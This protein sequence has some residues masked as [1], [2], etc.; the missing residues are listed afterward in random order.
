MK[1][2]TLKEVVEFYFD[3]HIALPCIYYN[4]GTKN[5]WNRTIES[6]NPTT[7]D[8]RLSRCKDTF[9]IYTSWITIKIESRDAGWDDLVCRHFW[10]KTF[11]DIQ[12]LIERNICNDENTTVTDM[13]GAW[14]KR[15]ASHPRFIQTVIMGEPVEAVK[16]YS[17]IWKRLTI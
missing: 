12:N 6:Y 4:A 3:R 2:I 5:M 16:T 14:M 13:G 9:N 15:T 10:G 7:G 1:E 17:I 8:F 11:S